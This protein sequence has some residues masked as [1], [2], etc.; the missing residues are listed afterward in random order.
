MFTA[1]AR[2]REGLTNRL[3][4]EV[5]GFG[6]NFELGTVKPMAGEQNMYQVIISPN[7]FLDKA[8]Y[9]GL[10]AS[11]KQNVESR[12]NVYAHYY[13]AVAAVATK[14]KI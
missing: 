2:S 11:I 1:V 9:D 7:V 4:L 12:R 14:S 8:N 10:L 5:I 6:E 3:K 13:N